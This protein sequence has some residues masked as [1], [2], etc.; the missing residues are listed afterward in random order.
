MIKKYTINIFKGQ[1]ICTY[2]L[3]GLNY[4]DFEEMNFG[5]PNC[6]YSELFWSVFSRIRTESR[7]TPNTDTFYAV[8]YLQDQLCKK[9]VG[10]SLIYLEMI[11]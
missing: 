10:R 8:Y 7:I 9:R 2:L 6:P 4:M 5:L 3:F 1:S 11:V